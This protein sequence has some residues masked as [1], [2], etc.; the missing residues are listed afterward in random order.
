MDLIDYIRSKGY[1][2]EIEGYSAQVPEQ[3]DFLIYLSNMEK[4]RTVLEIGFNA[5]HS[6]ELFLKNGCS[7]VTSFDIGH[8]PYVRFAKEYIDSFYPDRHELIL[9]ESEKS[10]P[11]FAKQHSGI[12]FDL[13]FIDGGHAYQTAIADL[14][15]CK[16]FSHENTIIVMDDVIKNSS[17]QAEYNVG[18]TAAWNEMLRINYVVEIGYTETSVQHRGFAWGRFMI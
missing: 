6:S 9:G 7:E 18:P 3:M 8:H 15:N 4:I 1:K 10:V 14:K 17:D 16:L 5:G 2:G 12:K 11:F 13:I